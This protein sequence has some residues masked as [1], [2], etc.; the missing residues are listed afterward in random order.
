MKGNFNPNKIKMLLE[1][2]GYGRFT[3]KKLAIELDHHVNRIAMW[4]IKSPIILDKIRSSGCTF[5]EFMNMEGKEAMFELNYNPRQ[6][7]RWNKKRP[8]LLTDLQTFFE[9]Y[10]LTFEE[11]YEKFN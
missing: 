3:D 5:K 2:K 9:K 10:N 4:K 11:I 8:K 7:Y 6:F 1:Y